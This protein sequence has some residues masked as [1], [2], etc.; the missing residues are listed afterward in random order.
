MPKAA[1]QRDFHYFSVIG[2]GVVEYCFESRVRRNQLALLRSGKCF[3]AEFQNFAGTIAKQ[4]LIVID[5]VQLCKFIDQQ[6]VVFV[7]ITAREAE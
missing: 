6:I 2:A 3:R 4:D 5:A 7:R 1:G